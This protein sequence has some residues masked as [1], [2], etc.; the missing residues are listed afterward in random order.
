[1]GLDIRLPI[2]G[3]FLIAGLLLAIYG[4]LTAGDTQLYERSLMINVNLWWGAVMLVFGVVMLV[5]GRRSKDAQGVHLTEDSAQGRATEERE[6][7]LG[8]ER[9]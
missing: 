2:G 6:Q 9:D 4:L 1:M 3:M 5:L 7:R 8:L